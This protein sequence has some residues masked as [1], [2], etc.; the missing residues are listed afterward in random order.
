MKT[1]IEGLFKEMDNAK[2]LM[3]GCVASLLL[4]NLGLI[5]HLMI[6]DGSTVQGTLNFLEQEITLL[7]PTS[8]VVSV[9]QHGVAAYFSNKKPPQQPTA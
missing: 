5:L 2:L 6:V 7:I 8:G 1:L 9:I 3:M 4:A